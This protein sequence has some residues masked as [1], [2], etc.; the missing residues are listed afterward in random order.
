LFLCSF[1]SVPMDVCVFLTFS[2]THFI[3]VLMYL[4]ICSYICL[5]QSNIHLPF[6]AER[7]IKASRSEP[8]KN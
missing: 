2:H 3:F 8:F 1:V 5:L 7:L 4:F 6:N